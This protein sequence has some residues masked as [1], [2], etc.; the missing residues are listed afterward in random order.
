MTLPLTGSLLTQYNA[1]PCVPLNTPL[2]DLLNLLYSL[3]GFSMP[4]SNIGAGVTAG[5]NNNIYLADA[6]GGDATVTLPTAAAAG[7][8]GRILVKKIDSSGNNVILS[9]AAADTIEGQSADFQW[10]FPL[11]S[12]TLISD[13]VN[14]WSSR[15]RRSS[16]R[17]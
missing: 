11:N 4:V 17:Q 16:P 8:G 5:A 6:T 12:Y 15:R 1:L 3:T 9:P 7:Q 14:G 10:N 2:G 13:G